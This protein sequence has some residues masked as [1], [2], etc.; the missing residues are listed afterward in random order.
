MVSG[1]NEYVANVGLTSY[2]AYMTNTKSVIKLNPYNKDGPR[3]IVSL[4]Y[5]FCEARHQVTGSILFVKVGVKMLC[6]SIHLFLMSYSMSL[7]ITI[8]VWRMKYINIPM[9]VLEG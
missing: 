6:V 8:I 5:I 3:Y 1:S 7:D 4:T 9:I 2:I